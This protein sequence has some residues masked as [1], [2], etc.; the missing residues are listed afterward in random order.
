MIGVLHWVVELGR[1]DIAY[2]IYVLS[3]YLVQSHTGHFVQMLHIFKYL[4]I[5]RM[6]IFYLTLQYLSYLTLL[7][8]TAKSNRLIICILTQSNIWHKIICH[9][10]ENLSMLVVSLTLT[11]PVIKS[12]AVINMVIYFTVI[13]IQLSSTIKVGLM[14]RD[15]HLNLNFWHFK[16][17]QKSL[18]SYVTSFKCS[19]FQY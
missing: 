3:R 8:S 15:P 11:T 4:G 13:N 10:E 18:F 1:I 6:V 14:C 5:Q 17:L 16:L 12:R 7:H 19:A 2:E 9:Q